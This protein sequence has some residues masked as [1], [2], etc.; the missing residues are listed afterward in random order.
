[1]FRVSLKLFVACLLA[2]LGALCVAQTRIPVSDLQ[3]TSVKADSGGVFHLYGRF[4]IQG[5][6]DS[7]ETGK[8]PRAF[9]SDVSY[10]DPSAKWYE[11]SLGSGSTLV[12]VKTN[13]GKSYVD[14]DFTLPVQLVPP[15]DDPVGLLAVTLDG[16]IHNRDETSL[17]CADYTTHTLSSPGKLANTVIPITIR[18]PADFWHESG[19]DIGDRD[20]FQRRS[21]LGIF[22]NEPWGTWQPWTKDTRPHA[23]VLL[24][25]LADLVNGK[26]GSADLREDSDPV[27][28]AQ[29]GNIEATLRF[30]RPTRK[31]THVL[32]VVHDHT[33]INDPASTTPNPATIVDQYSGII[34]AAKPCAPPCSY[35]PPAPAQTSARMLFIIEDGDPLLINLNVAAAAYSGSRTVRVSD[36]AAFIDK[37]QDAANAVAA[38]APQVAQLEIVSHGNPYSF[39]GIDTNDLVGT[40]TGA[41]TPSIAALLSAVVRPDGCIILTSCNS[42]IQSDVDCIAATVAFLTKRNTYGAK[43]YLTAGTFQQHSA[44]ASSQDREGTSGFGQDTFIYDDTCRDAAPCPTDQSFNRYCGEDALPGQSPLG[45][46][47]EFKALNANFAAL[48]KS[49]VSFIQSSS[50]YPNTSPH[51]SL[52]APDVTIHLAVGDDPVLQ[53]GDYQ[54]FANGTVLRYHNLVSGAIQDYCNVGFPQRELLSRGWIPVPIESDSFQ[55]FDGASQV[56]QTIPNT[57][58]A[59]SDF[60]VRITFRNIGASTWSSPDY[61]LVETKDDW[62]TNPIS[63][64]GKEQIRP[65]DTCT[66]LGSVTAPSI[67]GTY[68]MAWRATK[69]GVEFGLGSGSTNIT[70]TLSPFADQLVSSPT[71]I[72][73]PQ[74][75][76]SGIFFV[77]LRNVGTA[78]WSNA[79]GYNLYDLTTGTI[80]ALPAAVFPPTS[81]VG[82]TV[83]AHTNGI[84]GNYVRKYRLRHF[85]AQFGPVITVNVIQG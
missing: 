45:L 40:G 5:S 36:R 12:P 53:A 24:D 2:C 72:A 16:H 15:T 62:I 38:G 4:W 63:V 54:I 19:D 39:G 68:P 71:S 69:Q 43:G 7:W 1:M 59:A 85:Q 44:R 75:S 81:T 84:P 41:S 76:T 52:V 83:N 78:A 70:V 18:T 32:V 67:P 60:D 10:F 20:K 66:F 55:L 31:A 23:Y 58:S 37:L 33:Y 34:T 82:I 26:W 42:G 30:Y 57:V 3:V 11:L 8:E 56:A 13:Q 74:G 73:I 28:F 47:I 35:I 17:A 22:L 6:W 49:F 25:G 61:R 50:V 27:M 9:A 21:Q 51:V 77:T 79:D 80:S 65:G 29:T 64:D 14:F 48:L 46:S